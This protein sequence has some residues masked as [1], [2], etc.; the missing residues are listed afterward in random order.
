MQGLEL[1]FNIVVALV[2]GGTAA[3]W[4]LIRE[5]LTD[6]KDTVVS[7]IVSFVT[8][9]IVKKAIPKLISMFIP[10]AG[11]ISAILSIYDTIMVSVE[12]ISKII[13]VV[14]AFI[15]SIVTIAAGNITAAANR[16]ESILGGLLSL[17]ISFLAGILGLGKITDKIKDIIGKI[18]ASVDKAVDA[19]IAWI[20]AKAKALFGRLFSKKDKPN[21]RTDEQKKKDKLA[22]I[23][24]AEQALAEKGFDE[25]KVRGKLDSIK[26]RY[27]L[28]TLE[29]VVDSK[30]GQK[31]TVHFTASASEEEVG[32][33]KVV[34]LAA[35]LNEA[36]LSKPFIAK[37][38]AATAKKLAMT[39]DELRRQ[40]AIQQG[41]L[42]NLEV[43]KWKANW[44]KFYA[45]DGGRSDESTASEARETAIAAERANVVALWLTNNPGKPIA[46]A[47]TFV[48]KLFTRRPG[49]KTYPFMYRSFDS[50][51]VTYVNPV[52]GKTLLH[53]ADQAAGGGAETAGLGGA[54]ENFP[55]GAQWDRGG[56]AMI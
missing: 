10:G 30:D 3:A 13:Q 48:D 42:N 11:F 44:D 51:G 24:E 18:R 56:R 19:A 54:R 41:A 7:G 46:D 1:A 49:D 21:D 40:V 33:P 16:V 36:M 37:E 35:T 26:N 55:I 43:N 5:K 4:E 28:L 38:K 27:K 6:L 32:N 23:A 34:Q 25:Q 9:S 31:E 2:K 52:Y 20:V 29:L 15:D 47:N 22:P 39:R 8:D 53:A 45:P 17:A 50:N 14:T 12:K